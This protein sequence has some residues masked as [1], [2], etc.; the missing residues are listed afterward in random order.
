MKE[1]WFTYNATGGNY[2]V[3]YPQFKISGLRRDGGTYN[4]QLTASVTN[5]ISIF[6]CNAEYRVKGSTLLGPT[7]LNSQPAGVENKTASISFTVTPDNTGTAYIYMNP[8]A[9]Q[10]LASMSAFILKEN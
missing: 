6:T 2:N 10:T 7:T 1:S 9:G 8:V 3:L 5:S 4:L